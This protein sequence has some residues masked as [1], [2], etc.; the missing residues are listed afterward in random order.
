MRWRGGARGGFSETPHVGLC[1]S[2]GVSTNGCR[3]WGKRRHLSTNR[4]AGRW[5]GLRLQRATALKCGSPKFRS[6]E[7]SSLETDNRTN[8]TN[9]IK[10]TNWTIWT[11]L[12]G[13]R[14]KYR[15]PRTSLRTSLWTRTGPE[16][17]VLPVAAQHDAGGARRIQQHRP[18]VSDGSARPGCV[19]CCRSGSDAF[20]CV[21]DVFGGPGSGGAAGGGAAA[22][23]TH[24]GGVRVG[25]AHE[26]VS[27]ARH[28]HTQT[29]ARKLNS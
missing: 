24:A 1:G 28:T 5:A 2:A 21:Q 11:Q 9:R 23:G 15:I 18:E 7:L 4:S 25:Q 14:T 16:A 10:W 8:R 22:G 6:R 20:V 26:R 12:T 27:T 19:G 13:S 17:A 3:V 29:R